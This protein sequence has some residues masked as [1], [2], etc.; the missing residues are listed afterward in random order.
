MQEWPCHVWQ[1]LSYFVVSNE[2]A[3][4]PAR[5]TKMPDDVRKLWVSISSDCLYGLLDTSQIHHAGVFL[6]IFFVFFYRAA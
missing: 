3:E 4:I 1:N 6:K 2:S 5:H